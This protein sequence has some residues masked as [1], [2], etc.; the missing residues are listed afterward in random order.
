[1]YLYAAI[2]I[3]GLLGGFTSA[4][5]VQAWRHDAA[6]LARTQ[7]ESRDRVKKIERGDEAAAQH[8]GFKSKEE[9][10]YVTIT[11]QVDR[12]VKDPVY[13]NICLPPA[14]LQLAND[15]IAGSEPASEPAPAVP[16]P[17]AAR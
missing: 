3:A 13:R 6:A 11:K 4:W 1:M 10:R 12:V 7:A 15:A 2:L 14:G 17:P 8:E 5:K 9:V 16:G